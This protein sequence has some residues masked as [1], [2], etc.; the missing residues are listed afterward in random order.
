[1]SLPSLIQA[2][3][4]MWVKELPLAF[5]QKLARSMPR[6]IKAVMATKGQMTKY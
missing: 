6:R 5:F 2:I 3:K 1:M 4:M